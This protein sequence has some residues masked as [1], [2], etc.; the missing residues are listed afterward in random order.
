MWN[1]DWVFETSLASYLLESE[2]EKGKIPLLSFFLQ[3]YERGESMWVF[4]VNKYDLNKSFKEKL[5][6]SLMVMWFYFSLYG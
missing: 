3:D 5:K 4:E 6:S 1:L 2:D